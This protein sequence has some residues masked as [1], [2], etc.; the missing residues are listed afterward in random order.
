M[1]VT[2]LLRFTGSRMNVEAPAKIAW[3]VRSSRFS[4]LPRSARMVR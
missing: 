1:A 4:G 3:T 2:R